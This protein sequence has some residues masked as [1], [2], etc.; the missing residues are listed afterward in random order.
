MVKAADEAVVPEVAEVPVET[1]AAHD[2]AILVD[3]VVDG[4]VAI[5]V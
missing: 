4:R 5:E 1:A 2:R 3:V